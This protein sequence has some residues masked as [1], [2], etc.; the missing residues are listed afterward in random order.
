MI[1]NFYVLP[2]NMNYDDFSM[3]PVRCYTCGKPLH[4]PGQLYRDFLARGYTPEEALNSIGL[5]RYCCRT[6]I[7][8]PIVIPRGPSY[9]DPELLRREG[10]RSAQT[11]ISNTV[12]LQPI[13]PSIQTQTTPSLTPGQQGGT[14][15]IPSA[16]QPKN[17][18][19]YRAV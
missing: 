1:S 14:Q 8:N 10:Y 18:R 2:K 12:S 11:S 4:R 9:V 5:L 16:A 15:V 7:I 6:R 13:L 3:L 17:V 19:V